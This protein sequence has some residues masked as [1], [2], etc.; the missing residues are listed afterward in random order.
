MQCV[1]VF[2]DGELALERLGKC[3][4]SATINI[5][6]PLQSLSWFLTDPGHVVA[7]HG[8]PRHSAGQSDC[9]SRSLHH[10]TRGGQRLAINILKTKNKSV[11]IIFFLN[12]LDQLCLRRE[13]MIILT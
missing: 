1:G 8:K 4:A 7:A 11:K 2:G 3:C 5:S 12:P 9:L 13:R 10:W 6:N